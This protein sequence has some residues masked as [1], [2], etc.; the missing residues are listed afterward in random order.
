M[1]NVE[2]FKQVVASLGDIWASDHIYFSQTRDDYSA[3]YAPSYPHNT[4]EGE[5]AR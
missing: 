2:R 3:Q 5:L 4:K 1:T